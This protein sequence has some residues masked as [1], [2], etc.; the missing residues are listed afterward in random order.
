MEKVLINETMK[1]E[2]FLLNRL[3]QYWYYYIETVLSNETF[4]LM[5]L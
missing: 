1:G 5:W 3:S 2:T 4:S